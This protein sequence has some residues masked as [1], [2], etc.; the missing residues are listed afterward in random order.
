[1]TEFK[2]TERY[3]QGQEASAEIDY[4]VA[5]YRLFQICGVRQKYVTEI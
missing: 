4:L 2:Y 3:H 1:M 5:Y